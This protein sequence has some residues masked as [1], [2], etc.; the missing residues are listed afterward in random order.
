MKSM[1]NRIWSAVSLM[2]AAV[3]LITPLKAS[4][5]GEDKIV[6]AYEHKVPSSYTIA[7]MDTDGLGNLYYVAVVGGNQPKLFALSPEG[8]EKWSVTGKKNQKMFVLAD[9][10]NNV[11]TSAGTV[12][13]SYTASGKVNWTKNIG[14]EFT[15]SAGKNEI[16]ISTTDRVRGYNYSG[17]LTYDVKYGGEQKVAMPDWGYGV[18]YKTTAVSKNVSI[19]VYRGGNKLFTAKSPNNQPIGLVVSSPDGKNIYMRDTIESPSHSGHVY[20]YDTGG[21]LKWSY[22]IGEREWI[23]SMQVLDNGYIAVTSERNETLNVLTPDGKLAWKVNK[24]D[25]VEVGSIGNTIYYGNDIYD[26]EG[27]LIVSVQNPDGYN[28]ISAADGAIL[29]QKGNTIIRYTIK[30]SDILTSWAY[31]SIDRLITA[32]IVS[33][34]PDGSFKPSGN[35]SKEE[36]LKMLLTA[37]PAQSTTLPDSSPF[38][39]VAATRWSYSIIA[40]AVT[41]GI[42]SVADEGGKLN[43]SSAITREQMAVYTAK[44]LKLP[45]TA[46]KPF[47]DA[48]SISYHPDLI[49]AAASSGIIGGYADG[50]FK[51]KGNLTRAEAAVVITRVLDYK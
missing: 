40:S 23:S 3:L 14:E 24:E 4:A 43:P 47:T 13:T 19:D 2:L 45:V 7:S 16:V 22:T 6:K 29:F 8:K 9:F 1:K 48:S 35:V 32:G 49:S 10:K 38:S 11:Y 27:N 51:P 28:Y 46:T 50:S 20:A 44:A 33:G 5:A 18:W 26:K 17:K 12:L 39:D 36:Y 37:K 15:M 30:N 34:Y 42:L 25:G 41:S 21:K 31:P